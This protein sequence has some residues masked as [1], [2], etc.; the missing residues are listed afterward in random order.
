MMECDLILQAQNGNTEAM[1]RL[2]IHYYPMVFAFFYRNTNQYHQSK[3]LTQE[4]F[5]KMVVAISK[6]RPQS[7]FKSWLFTIAS[8]HLKN[9]YRSRSRHPEPA[10]LEE[11]IPASFDEAEEIAVRNDIRD[12]LLEL[13]REQKEVIILHYYQEFSFREI[14]EITGE[15]E[16][17]LKARAR[18]GLNKLRSKWGGS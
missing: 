7:K 3:D 16:S 9:Y 4:V 18:Y 17:T 5:I 1:N 10:E 14:A 15:N 13:P 6:Y 2:I 8:N 12:A 11:N